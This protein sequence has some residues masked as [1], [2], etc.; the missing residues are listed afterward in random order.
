MDIG[1]FFTTILT[2]GTLIGNILVVLF[3][4]SS[5][6]AKEVFRKVSGF[7]S[8]HALRFGFLVAFAATFGSL[9]YAQV[10][11]YPACILCWIQRIFMY[12]EAALFGLALWKNDRGVL[13]YALFLAVLGGAVALYNWVKDMLAMYTNISLECPVVPGLPSC[14]RI[15]VSG[16]G[17][18]T[19]AM[20][21]LNAFIFIGLISYFAIRNDKQ[22]T[23]E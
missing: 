2:I 22:Q 15:Y 19:I 17:Y 16:F 14:D 20:F 6:F 10:T 11:G 8:E 1:N 21:A 12:P 9:I 3:L 18:I 5:V 4:F 13:P 7:M 23:H